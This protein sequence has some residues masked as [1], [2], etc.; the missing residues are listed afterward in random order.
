V[1]C[2]EAVIDWIAARGS[3]STWESQFHWQ[4]WCNLVLFSTCR[5]RANA[6]DEQKINLQLKSALREESLPYV[7]LQL[8]SSNIQTAYELVTTMALSALNHVEDDR[9]T[10]SKICSNEEKPPITWRI[11]CASESCSHTRDIAIYMCSSYTTM[12]L[13][14]W[15]HAAHSSVSAHSLLNNTF[16]VQPQYDNFNIKCERVHAVARLQDAVA[17]SSEWLKVRQR[18]VGASKC[19]TGRQRQTFESA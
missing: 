1:T 17:A 12:N 6:C 14:A 18:E 13:Y 16:E 3:A 8:S 5:L 2:G 19:I 10:S 9:Q 15:H 11:D 4:Q 7:R